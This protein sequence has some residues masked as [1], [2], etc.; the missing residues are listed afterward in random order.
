MGEL[1]IIIKKD[2]VHEEAVAEHRTPKALEPAKA[3]PSA[4]SVKKQVVNV[5]QGGPINMDQ[6]NPRPNNKNRPPQ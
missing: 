2:C 4:S 5:R 6:G 1:M 3:L